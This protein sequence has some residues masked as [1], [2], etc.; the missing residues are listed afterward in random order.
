MILNWLYI[1]SQ[2]TDVPRD[3]IAD[4]LATIK[5]SAS[6]IKKFKTLNQHEKFYTLGIFNFSN[7]NKFLL[8]NYSSVQSLGTCLHNNYTKLVY[9]YYVLHMKFRCNNANCY[10]DYYNIIRKKYTTS[11]EP[12]QKI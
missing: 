2:N 11:G 1:T 7:D 3:Y 5:N 12:N 4:H 6:K 8:S 9:I 10:D